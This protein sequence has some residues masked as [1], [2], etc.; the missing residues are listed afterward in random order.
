MASPG[1]PLSPIVSVSVIVSPSLGTPPP[2]NIGLIVGPSAVIANNV[3]LVEFSSAAALLTYGFTSSDPEYIA[4]E[5]YFSQVPAP[6]NVFVGLKDATSLIGAT[7][8][9]AGS[10]YAVGDTGT[11]AGGTA[12]QL[13]TYEVLTI[14]G[15]GSTGPVGTFALLT[16]GTGYT[17]A[18]GVTTTATTGSGS[19]FTVTTT[20]DVGETSLIAVERCRAAS[21]QWYGVM[22][23]NA[24]DADHEAIA[25][26]C[27]S[28]DNTQPT[29]YFG[30]SQTATIPTAATTD[31][32]SVLQGDK[33]SYCSLSYSTTQG[34][35]APNNVYAAAAIMGV[36]MGLNTG[37]PGFYFT[38]MFKQ[39]VGIT[40][41]PLTTAQVNYCLAKN[42]NIYVGY[43]NQYTI[44]QPGITPAGAGYYMDLVLNRDILKLNIQY[45]VMNLLVSSLSVPQ[46]DAGEA[47]LIHAV[48]LACAQAV[49]SGYLAT[50]GT[51]SGTVPIL[52]LQPG[53]A[54]PD[55][56]IALAAP[57]STQSAGAHAARQAMPITVVVNEANAIQSVV[58]SVLVN[59]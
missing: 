13:A 27:Q 16:G 37:A 21:N 40:P 53:A 14:T 55:G 46:D 26:Y 1:L 33:Y 19:G 30:N 35:N 15:G 54:I 48:N 9:A 38:M 57:F 31:V 56:Y 45:N 44:F 17:A 6:Q 20:G 51:Y 22:V 47:Q 58:I 50:N 18:V 36:E 49:T 28:E 10:G 8:D 3:R 24:T 29:F 2:L 34:G 32:A 41:E 11:I 5:L 42:C 39:V 4:A 25:L 59:P 23:C 7:L 12:G 43:V 52:T